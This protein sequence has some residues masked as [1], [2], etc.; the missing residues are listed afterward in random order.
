MHPARNERA[1]LLGDLNVAPL[2]HDVWSHKQLLDV[3]SH[4]PIECEKL[5]AAQKSGGWIDTMRQLHAGAEEALYVVELPLAGLGGGRQGPPPRSHLG[6]AGARRQD[7][8]DQ[9]RRREA[10][11]WKQ[12]SD[13]VPVTATLEL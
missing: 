12:P 4:T 10:R 1:I 8:E 5:I 2:E 9:D 11:G 13:H 3:V 7:C 6:L